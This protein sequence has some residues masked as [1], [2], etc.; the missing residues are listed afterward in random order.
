M[1]NYSKRIVAVA[2]ILIVSTS[3]MGCESE[4]AKKQKEIEKLKDQMFGDLVY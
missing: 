4:E 1:K 2:A 3:F